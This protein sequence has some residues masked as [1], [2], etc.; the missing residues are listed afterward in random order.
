M[1]IDMFSFSSVILFYLNFK[2][3]LICALGFFWYV[4]ILKIWSYLFLE[5]TLLFFNL[6]FIEHLL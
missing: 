5:I 6:P 3:H 4:F 1:F 2:N